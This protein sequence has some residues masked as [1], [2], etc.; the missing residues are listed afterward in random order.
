MATYKGYFKPKNPQ[1]YKGDPTNIVYRS[2]WEL[3]V[4]NRFDGDPNVIWWQSEETIIP[5]R[6][7]IDG[8]YHRYFTDF[9]VNMRT[10]DGKIKTAIVEV[11]PMAQ[12]KPPTVQKGGSKNR[13]YINEV[14]TWGVNDAKW[15]AAREYC[16][17]RGY[18]FII[19]TE[20][21]LGLTF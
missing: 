18:E 15:K 16:K 3:I 5:Y 4:M 20:K 11:K 13:R 7:P 21:E 8:R 19:I 9:T 12:T 6:S 14:M 10:A 2:R 17:D 1:K